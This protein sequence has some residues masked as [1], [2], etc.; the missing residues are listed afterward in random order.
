MI[1]R[2]RRDKHKHSHSRYA[3]YKVEETK[4]IKEVKLEENVVVESKNPFTKV[5]SFLR[6]EKEKHDQE[7]KEKNKLV[8]QAIKTKRDAGFDL[9]SEK[10]KL[11][12]L[13]EQTKE[14]SQK[15]KEEKKNYAKEKKNLKQAKKKNWGFVS[16]VIVCLVVTVACLLFFT[17]R[18]L[19][20]TW[21]NLKMDELLYQ[22]TAPTEG[23]GTDMYW[24]FFYQA[25]IPTI[26]CLV[27]VIGIMI[28]IAYASSKVRRIAKRVLVCGSIICIG[29][30]GVTFNN[31]LDVKNYLSNKTDESTFIEDNYVDPSSV[32]IT[33]SETKRNLV[34]IYLE[35][36][37]ITYADEENGGGFEENDIPELTELS[38]QNENFSGTNDTLNGAVSLSGTTWTMGGLFASS[39]GLPLIT[40][41][42][43]WN[44]MDTQDSFF[45]E[46][47]VLGD[48]LKDNGYNQVF[49]CGSDATFGG[50][51]LYFT[52]HGDYEIHD[53]NYRKNNGDLDEDYYVWWGF[54]D[55]KLIQWAKDDLTQLATSDE[56]FNYT[57]LTVDTHFEDGYVCDQC[58]DEHDGNQYANVMSCSS[59]QVSELVSWIQ[60]QDWYENTT[61][62]ITG[63]HPT[64]DSDFCDDV[65]DDYQR[66]VYTTYINAQPTENNSEGMRQY[67][68]FDTFPTV[69]ASLGASIEG[70]RLGLG[71]NLFSGEQTIV[72]KDGIEYIN[73]EF[74]KT[75]EFLNSLANIDYTN[76]GMRKRGNGL[77][78][79]VNLYSI[80]NDSLYFLCS[81]IYGVNGTLDSVEVT[82]QDT[83]GN[84][85]SNIM[86]YQ[87]SGTF[88]TWINVPNGN[89]E[90]IYAKVDV[91]ST[92]SD[93]ESVSETAYEYYGNSALLN[94]SHGDFEDYLEGLLELDTDRY[95]ILITSQGEGSTN[96]SEDEKVLLGKLGAGNVAGSEGRASFAIIENGDAYSKVSNDYLREDG[97][98]A[99]ETPYAIS[100]SSNDEQV[101]SILL[102]EEYEEYSYEQEGINIVVWDRWN[103]TV[104][105]RA[106]FETED[107][108]PSIKSVDVKTSMFNNDVEVIANNPK[109]TDGAKKIVAVMYDDE[110]CSDVEEVTMSLSYDDTYTCTFENMKNELSH[111]SISIYEVYRD[112]SR[113]LLGSYSND[114]E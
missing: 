12:Q 103:H 39:S 99:D 55:Q 20:R 30:A 98:L 81:D 110:D 33:F 18:W 3:R 73:S 114:S 41:F 42:T 34:M 9:D 87:G 10:Y 101:S 105:S 23:T 22:L 93:G 40:D 27:I 78:L 76:D 79:D 113:V 21:P 19:F 70:N 44:S 106:S 50:R 45:G 1:K 2:L 11:N 104:T 16:T 111:K 74:A 29:I 96:I 66:R 53:I 38:E 56:P 36:M 68:T 75:S 4:I 15:V 72:E 26:I 43:D 64:M 28:F 31:K 35:S 94:G 57:M 17:V 102:G 59:R 69:V 77:D 61:I 67:S 108:K 100:S 95:T 109:H 97:I 47:T 112:Y 62:V 32:D 85:T 88:S 14:Q 91:H 13:K 5:K 52:S 65:D 86:E 58:I 54:E 63:D 46:A 37:E 25:G 48:I 71:T 82:I 24:Q 84:I 6:S 7:I 8:D 83:D 51:K 60:Q 107:K 89:T 80:N 92:D 49:A 90:V